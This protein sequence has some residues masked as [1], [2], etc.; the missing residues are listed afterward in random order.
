MQ[1]RLAQRKRREFI[2][3]PEEPDRLTNHLYR[4]EEGSDGQG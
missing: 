1:N 4:L 3:I 2:L